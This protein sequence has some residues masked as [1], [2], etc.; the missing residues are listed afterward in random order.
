MRRKIV[1]EPCL[2]VK[3]SSSKQ[4]RRECSNPLCVA[5]PTPYG[6][7]CR[8]CATA[9]TQRWRDN[10]AD[11]LLVRER[12]RVFPDEQLALRRAR[13]YVH[14]LVRRKKIKPGKCEICREER[15]SPDW[16][17]PAKPK[18]VRWFCREHRR[19]HADDA[20]SVRKGLAEL[21]VEFAT[22]AALPP[23]TLR[24]LHSAALRGLDGTGA[25]PG[26]LR[27]R[28]ALQF[29]YREMRPAKPL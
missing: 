3:R 12:A 19:E 9:A 7:Y 26:S 24:R 16:D 15:V 23:D 10:H 21:R 5:P 4:A 1:V 8:P 22:I 11:E 13:A 6:R 27:Y 25:E 18:A 28:I 2:S 17:D 14:A 29:A 20:A